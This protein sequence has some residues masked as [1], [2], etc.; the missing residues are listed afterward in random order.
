M[1]T[2]SRF[3]FGRIVTASKPKRKRERAAAATIAKMPVIVEAKT[4]KQIDG[5]KR[6]E[7]LYDKD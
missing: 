4:P 1:T 5:I 7:R 2:D 3:P 6:Y